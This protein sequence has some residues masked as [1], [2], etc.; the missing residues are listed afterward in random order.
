MAIAGG[1]HQ[2]GIK[3][4]IGGKLGYSQGNDIWQ[5]EHNYAG[6]SIL[7]GFMDASGNSG[8]Q[9]LFNYLLETGKL[10]GN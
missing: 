10:E 2:N 8:L 6:R 4:A 5:G 9:E 7:M 3:G 1:L